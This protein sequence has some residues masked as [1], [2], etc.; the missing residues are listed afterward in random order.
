MSL[1]NSQARQTASEQICSLELDSSPQ[2]HCE[3][4][5]ADQLA[6]PATAGPVKA[7]DTIWLSCEL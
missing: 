2:F 3:W 1:W 6:Q 4:G 7:G 5:T